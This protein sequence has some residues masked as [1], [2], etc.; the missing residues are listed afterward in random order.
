[1]EW[2]K[3]DGYSGVTDKIDKA[4]TRWKTNMIS[5]INTQFRVTGG[6]AKISSVKLILTTLVNS[7]T[8]F[9]F[10]L[11]GWMGKFYKRLCADTEVKSAQLSYKE[12]AEMKKVAEEEAME[13]VITVLD[14]IF[15]EMQKI[16]SPGS[17][18]MSMS[19]GISR[20]PT[21]LYGSLRCHAFIDELTLAQ[22]DRHP[23]LS[24]S[25]NNFCISQRASVGALT[26]LELRLN[27][28]VKDQSTMS[29]AL[30]KLTSKTKN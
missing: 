27:S 9:W 18:A 11:R 24:P 25:L 1:V 17:P 14:D 2:D 4:V 10:K 8:A 26:R 28:V 5:S 20:T 22:F 12:H 15:G 21:I 6:N 29:S 13:L 16:R 19:S 23:C 3:G 30:H 7:S